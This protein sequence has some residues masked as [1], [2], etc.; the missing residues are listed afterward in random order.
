MTTERL[1]ISV[2][3]P[4]FDF[5]ASKFSMLLHAARKMVVLMRFTLMTRGGIPLFVIM[6]T[7][8]SNRGFL[9]QGRR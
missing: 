1:S 4:S 9:F 7:L 5:L 3:D 8:D 2:S 6:H